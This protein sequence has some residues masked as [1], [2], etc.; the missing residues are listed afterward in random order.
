MDARSCP[1]AHSMDTTWY[2]VDQD[3]FV[4][5]FDTGEDGALPC[6]AVCGPEGGKFE[7]WPLDALAIARALV[8][9]TLP[10]TRAEPLTPKVTYHAVLVLAPDATPDPRAS[11]RDAEGR[12]YAVQELL[13]SAVAV[14]RD[15]APRIVASRRP[16]TAKELTR[17]GADPRITRI[18]LDREIWEWD[19][20]PIFR[21]DN[22]TYGNPGAYAR[23][24][25]PADPLA[26]NDLPP[27]LREPLA[28][29]R[30]PLRFAATPSFH[31]ADYL[32][33][34][35]CDTYGD[36]TL[37]GEPREPEEPPPASAATTTRGRR[38]WVL[39][40]AALAVLLILAWVFGR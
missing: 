24:H 2:A 12:T 39:I 29:L 23:S 34:E 13:G 6:D 36:T 14:V 37:R 7:S 20:K 31:L 30:L 1:A 19:E 40:A 3:G 17:L 8:Q 22:D 27:E 33:D 10:A 5:E 11:S 21:F 26:L 18:V 32:S 4:G 9:G 16:L 15:A 38:S 28:G 25:S 35:A